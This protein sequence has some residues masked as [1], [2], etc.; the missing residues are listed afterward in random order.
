MGNTPS[1]D[2]GGNI[3]F[4]RPTNNAGL[5]P[6]ASSSALGVDGLVAC[7]RYAAMDGSS[8]VLF[9]AR[10]NGAGMPDPFITPDEWHQ[11]ATGTRPATD[12]SGT[13]KVGFDH[14]G[15]NPALMVSGAVKS[16]GK[17]TIMGNTATT[18]WVP[19]D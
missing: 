1:K 2:A 5:I 15:H 10:Y 4:S 9:C 6:Y 17:G 16:Y 14:V 18:C 7:N 19:Q 11:D 8:V 12:P 13:V 3:I